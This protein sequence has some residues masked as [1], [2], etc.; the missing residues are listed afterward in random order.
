MVACLDRVEQVTLVVVAVLAGDPIRV[1]LGQEVDALVG[2]EVV[3]HPEQLTACIDPAVGVAG[4]AVHVTPRLRDTAVPHQIGDLMRR[5]RHQC[6]EVPLHVVVAKVVGRHALLAADEILELHRV[7]HEEHRRVVA[8]HVEVAVT[9]IELQREPAGV[10]PGVGAATL[11]CHGGEPGHHL[12]LGAGLED[13]GLGV[14]AD[15]VGHLEM[16]E[17]AAA[18]GVGLP[19]RNALP[20]EV[21]HL[22]DQ[23]VVLQQNRAVGADGERMFDAGDRVACVVGRVLVGHQ[24]S[25]PR[26]GCGPLGWAS[27]SGIPQNGSIQNVPRQHGIH[28]LQVDSRVSPAKRG[29]RER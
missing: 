17:R 13:R 2:L 7:T 28:V 3:L 6:P 23:V 12:G 15:V 18:L 25:S 21:G 20:V 10:T 27:P 22:L 5:L 29:F 8:D 24:V 16:T 4:V 19:L 11:A 26:R 1:L 9:R 14:L